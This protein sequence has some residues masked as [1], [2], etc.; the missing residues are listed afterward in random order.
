MR[1]CYALT[2]HLLPICTFSGSSSTHTHH[3]HLTHVH[4]ASPKAADATPERFIAHDSS[5]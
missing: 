2:R 3:T 5:V 4:H 1:Q